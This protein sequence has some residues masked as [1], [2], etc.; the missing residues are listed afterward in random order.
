MPS[1]PSDLRPLIVG[2]DWRGRPTLTAQLHG[3][4]NSVT[5]NYLGECTLTY[6][7]KPLAAVWTSAN[8]MNGKY[9]PAYGN[10]DTPPLLPSRLNYACGPDPFSPTLPGPPLF[11][12]RALG[13]IYTSS[14]S[15]DR[16]DYLKIW[17]NGWDTAGQDAI[18]TYAS[19][20]LFVFTGGQALSLPGG[21]VPTGP[22]GYRFEYTGWL[23]ACIPQDDQ[24]DLSSL[25]AVPHLRFYDP[26]EFIGGSVY[27]ILVVENSLDYH[28]H[29]TPPYEFF[30]LDLAA[31]N[32]VSS[33]FRDFRC[34]LVSN[35]ASPSPANPDP[36]TYLYE[37]N[38]AA[39][40]IDGHLGDLGPAFRRED[41][42][43][44]SLLDLDNDIRQFFGLA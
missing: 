3:V 16:G 33:R 13:V 10:V 18:A 44:I 39:D 15:D 43:A 7:V 35:P 21:L 41:G 32:A 27:M 36:D 31:W 8:Y 40:F 25:T 30:P 4:P 1:F 38:W 11:S 19:A 26:D 2:R 6:S 20:G 42:S 17:K 12:P 14:D 9:P 37:A 22:T 24:F 23:M 5:L 29:G 28:T 34:V